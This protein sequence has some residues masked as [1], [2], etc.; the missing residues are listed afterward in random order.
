MKSVP[1]RGSGWGS[2]YKREV[3]QFNS[4]DQV[5]SLST[6]GPTRYRKVVLTSLNGD[7]I[8]CVSL[9]AIGHGQSG[10]PPASARWS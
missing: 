4:F 6:C 2:G 9:S 10:D 8:D 5:I 3:Q 7:K 1:P